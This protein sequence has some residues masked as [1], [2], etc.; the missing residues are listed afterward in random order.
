MPS[1]GFEDGAQQFGDLARV[2]RQVGAGELSREL[3]KAISDAAAPVADEIK[4]TAHLDPYLPDRYAAVLSLDLKVTTHKN[5]SLSNPGVTIF[6]R[7]PTG[8][9]GRKI[10]HIN[11]GNLRHPVFADR[12]APRRSWRWRDQEVTPGF[13]TD[14][15]EAAAPR[16]RD[17]IIAAVV[18]VEEKAMKGIG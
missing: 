3:Y 6:A 4:S 5:T 11:A 9:G 17:A 8:R 15:C 12:T 18:R 13:F 7:A 1:G 14:P 10:R 16:I 2:L